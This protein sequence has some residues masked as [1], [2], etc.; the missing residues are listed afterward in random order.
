MTIPSDR[1]IDAVV[2]SIQQLA[3]R[4]DPIAIRLYTEQAK[5]SHRAARDGYPSSTMGGGSNH[6]GDHSDPTLAAV[7]RIADDL[8]LYNHVE[9]MWGFLDEAERGLRAHL[10]RMTTLD[11][12]TKEA[13]GELPVDV[14]YCEAFSAAGIHRPVAHSGTVGGRL[15]HAMQLSEHAYQFVWKYGRLPSVEEC[16]HHDLKGRWQVKLGAPA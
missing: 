3:R 8:A 12:L 2:N 6:H 13:E 1:S 14:V 9:Q 5:A 4:L 10:S 16:R 15:D 11:Q 7:E